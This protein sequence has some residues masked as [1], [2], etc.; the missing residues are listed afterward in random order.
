MNQFQIEAKSCILTS[1]QF[2]TNVFFYFL[3]VLYL[4]GFFHKLYWTCPVWHEAAQLTSG[5][6]ILKYGRYDLSPVNPPLTKILAGLP[7]ITLS[8]TINPKVFDR[9]SFWRDEFAK[10]VIFIMDNPKNIRSFFYIARTPLILNIVLL[11]YCF[12]KLTSVIYNIK[13]LLA[14]PFLFLCLTTPIF[15]GN[16]VLLMSDVTTSVFAICSIYYFC[17][18]LKKPGLENALILGLILGLSELCKF[19][20]LIFYPLLFVMWII[21][22]FARSPNSPLKTCLKQIWQ[23]ALV[24][25]TSLLVINMGYVFEGSSK[26]LREYHFQSTLFSGIHAINKV[27]RMGSNRFDGSGNTLETVLGYLPIPL[28]ENYIKGIDIQVLD[29]ERGMSSYLR[30]QWS[31]H[32]WWYYYLYALLIKM[33]LGTIFLFLLAVFCTFFLKGYNVYWYDEM[34]ILLPGIV[35]LAFVSSQTGFSIHS[36]YAIPALPFFLVWMSKV[37]LAFSGIPEFFLQNKQKQ[38]KSKLR[39]KIGMQIKKVSITKIYPQGY[40]TVRVLTIVFLVW[41]VLSSLSVYPHSL[42]YFNE[43]AVIIPTPKSDTYPQISPIKNPNSLYCW[44][45]TVISAGPRNGPRH[46]LDSNIDWG[47]DLFYLELWCKN[48][49]EVN[50][51]KI[52]YCGT[53][54]IELTTIPSKNSP[55]ETPE[56]GWCAIS[57][58]NIYSSDGQ[59]R[60]FLNYTPVAMA[61]YSIYIYHLTH[62]EIVKH[63]K[64][65]HVDIKP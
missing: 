47:Q 5:L 44:F 65:T 22:R 31:N 18:W 6:A 43:L 59:Y 48:H 14:I 11:C 29:F 33:P 61:G 1:R 2:L 28:P 7:L 54:P 3:V 35:L 39:C 50:S 46:L 53:Y 16:A 23:L 12:P 9:D 19:T 15:S 55:S 63:E 57:V 51:I 64:K 58:N 52:S 45:K 36:R 27:S 24:F 41:S 4:L 38:M 20:L 40:K 60:Y 32:G 17:N 37:G 34:I 13:S 30:G 42:S 10:S 62:S 26:Q 25:F 21:Y 56:P 8:P 49:P